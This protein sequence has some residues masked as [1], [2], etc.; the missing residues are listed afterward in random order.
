MKGKKFEVT[1]VTKKERKRN[2][3][4]SFTTSSLQQEAARKLNFRARK[5]MMLAQQLYEGIELSKKEGAVG[6]ITYMRTD[7]TRISDTAKTEA[8]SY[9]ESKYGKE[10]IAHDIKPVKAKANAQD[11]HEAIRPTS[12]MRAPEELKAVLSRDQ[13]RLYRLIWE[14]FI[15]SQMASAVLD[16]VTVDLQNNDV[17]FRANGSQIK[18]YKRN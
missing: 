15:A 5:T 18:R 7:S 10:F 1:N 4:P 2:P 3:T 6:L 12:A 17:L 13:L 16:T 9:I 11:A 8:R 14:R